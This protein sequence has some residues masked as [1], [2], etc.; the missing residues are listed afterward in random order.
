MKDYRYHA[1]NARSIRAGIMGRGL[2]QE[3][4]YR[5]MDKRLGMLLELQ[6]FAEGAAGAGDGGDAGSAVTGAEGM[7]E[8]A[9]PVHRRAR[10]NRFAGVRFGKEPPQSAAA[11]E[12]LDAAG[13]T[14]QTKATYDELIKG[15]YKAD[16]D[17]Y[18][19]KLLDGRFKETRELKS[20]MGKA[21]PILAALADRYGIDASDP[22]ALDLDELQ[23]KFDA[24]TRLY[25]D[26]ALREGVP[27]EL[28]IKKRQ[29]ERQQA[30]IDAQNRR[31]SEETQARAEM[32]ELLQQAV[33]LKASVPE[34]D[35][36]AEMENPAFGRMVL[37]PPRGVGLS[38][39]QAYYA[40]HHDEI[41]RA[42]RAQ[43]YRMSR[44]V[45]AQ[46]RQQVANTVA[47]GMQRPT[48]NGV[49][50]VA[51]ATTRA[52]PSK[53]SKAERAEVKRRV[54]AGENIYL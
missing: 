52:D 42:H 6:R 16:H 47:A 12:G 38:V 41:E 28:Y 1:R 45:A 9:A 22:E 29:L 5:M 21:A 34:F 14:Q 50:S 18:V 53:W 32:S 44:E 43:Q 46:T 25:E 2:P 49:A 30:A 15:E 36:N 4:E 31:A 19:K 48:E 35:I 13:T 37:K 26:E 8:V 24:D 51:T 11:E 33:A 27:V 10:V 17:A 3:G 39:E 20:R 23:R 40:V 54:R 7:Q